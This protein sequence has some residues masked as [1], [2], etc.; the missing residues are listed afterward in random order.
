MTLDKN[1]LEYSKRSY[2]HDH[3]RF[4]WSMLTDRPPVQW[5]NGKTLAVWI[6]TSLQ[7]YPLNQRGKPFKVPNGMTMPY[8]DLRHFTL[9]DYGNRVGIYRCL[10]AFERYD[11]KPTF[12]INSQ[13]ALET[14][15]LMEQL[16]EAGGE[17]ICHGW[18]MDHLHYGGQDIEE[19]SEIVKRSVDTL[20]R[21]VDSPVRGWLSPAKNQ[22]WNTP[23]LLAENGIEYC[24]DWV[25]D[26]MPYRF[27][28][29]RGPLTMMPL[30]T[31]IEDQFII[32]QNLH[33]ED[34]WVEQV[35]DAFDFLLEESNSQ[36][37]RMLALNIHPW[38]IGQPHRIRSLELVLEYIMSHSGVWQATAGEIFDAVKQQTLREG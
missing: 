35:K 20:R 38:L 36:G 25:N 13:L 18:N 26:D 6:N 9:R 15:Y 17:F 12:A 31:E 33:S 21:L 1:Y 14:P 23:E 34:S 8:P 4:Q 5:G 11:I 2:G 37:G 28:T 7:F 3:N 22:S 19:E 24:C 10:K 30:S 32:G 27:D 16:E 29:E